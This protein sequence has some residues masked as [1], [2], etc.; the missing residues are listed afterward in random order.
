[1]PS[2][3]VESVFNPHASSRGLVGA[4]LTKLPLNAL[5]SKQNGNCNAR[6]PRASGE[7]IGASRREF[8]V[9]TGFMLPKPNLFDRE[10]WSDDLDLAPDLPIRVIRHA[11]SARLGHGY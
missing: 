1:M 6:C 11:N 10:S 7:W 8:H 9:G 5:T 3:S 2:D 4:E